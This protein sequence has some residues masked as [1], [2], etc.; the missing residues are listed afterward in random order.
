MIAS[1]QPPAATISGAAQAT[2]APITA[3]LQCSNLG[4]MEQVAYTLFER[5]QSRGTPIRVVTPRPWGKGRPRLQKIDP[6]AEAFAYRGKFG[7]RTFPQFRRRVQAVEK[8]SQRVWVIGTCVSCLMA[9]RQSGRKTILSHHYHHFENSTSRLKWTAFYLAFGAGLD[10]ITYPTEFTRNEALRI[11]PWLR[12][13]THVVRN[14]FDVHYKTEEQR[15]EARRAARAALQMPPDSFIVGNAGWLIPRKRFDI[16]LKTAQAVS[17]QVE[18][19]RFY[20]CG[21][22]PEEQRLRQLAAD[23]GIADKVYFQ[24]WV[25]NMS[26]YY[27]AWDALLFNTDFDALGNSPLEAAS[28]GCP[29]VASCLYG[30]LSE[31]IL[32]GQT[33]FLMHHHDPERLADQL[34]NL[35][36]NPVLSQ[37]I[38]TRAVA[39]LKQ[40]F[41][42]EAAIRFY[43]DY[44]RGRQ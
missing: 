41:S 36:A 9:A 29:S 42:N 19:A 32:D 12:G 33:G 38:R 28:H 37:A 2:A 27:Q 16:F 17:R 10:A 30:G 14:G 20:I 21:G 39:T 13:K 44:F 31:F 22:G 26:V 4:G 23:L 1:Q 15:L 25:E 24:G 5:L 3:L 8:N 11:A 40:D 34:I 18:Q 7:W 43:E 35:A 6:S